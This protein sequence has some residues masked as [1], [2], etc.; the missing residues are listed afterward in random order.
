M[1]F[2]FFSNE[3]KTEW[4]Y[5]EPRLTS[6]AEAC[7]KMVESVR[8]SLGHEQVRILTERL[9]DDEDPDPSI[10]FVQ[11]AY[12]EPCQSS[13]ICYK[14]NEHNNNNNNSKNANSTMSEEDKTYDPMNYNLHTNVRTFIQEEKLMDQN[15]PDTEPEMA[16]T[17][18]R[19]LVLTGLCYNN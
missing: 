4:I 12:V 13:E 15:V 7:D 18:L 8:L 9:A 17:A 2:S 10:A 11:V 16:R 14:P 1:N 6:L 19:R 3:H 5:R